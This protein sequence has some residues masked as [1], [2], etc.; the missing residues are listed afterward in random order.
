MRRFSVHCRWQLVVRSRHTKQSRKR[1]FRHSLRFLW[2]SV[3]KRS[4]DCRPGTNTGMAQ[5]WKHSPS[6]NVSRVRFPNPASYVGWVCC[7]FSPLLR[8]FSSGFCGFP[9]PQKSTFLNSNSIW[10]QWMKSHLVEMPLQIPL[11]LLFHEHQF[12]KYFLKIIKL[13][14][15]YWMVLVQF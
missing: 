13:S 11:L 14:F 9:P 5:W 12:V 6:T 7:W 3:K 4:A 2:R 15:F 10:K 8:G 1:S